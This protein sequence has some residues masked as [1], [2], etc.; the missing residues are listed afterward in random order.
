MTHFLEEGVTTDQFIE[1]NYL[2]VSPNDTQPQ[3]KGHVCGKTTITRHLRDNTMGYNGTL[4]GFIGREEKKCGK[5]LAGQNLR[6]L[7]GGKKFGGKKL[8][9]KNLA[10]SFYRKKIRR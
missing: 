1:W 6:E 7:F 4:G 8:G 3:S 2:I 9:V 5:N 10:G